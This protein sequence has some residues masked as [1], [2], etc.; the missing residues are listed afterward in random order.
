MSLDQIAKYLEYNI[1]IIIIM[2]KSERPR[3]YTR[4][5]VE[6]STRLAE[7]LLHNPSSIWE[8][9]EERYDDMLMFKGGAILTSHDR[10]CDEL[11][12]LLVGKDGKN[13]GKRTTND[14][15]NEDEDD[16]TK[17]IKSC[18]TSSELYQ[19]VEWKFA[20]GKPRHALWKFLK[21][22][23][24]QTVK[25]CSRRA[26]AKVR[27][28]SS[29]NTNNDDNDEDEDDIDD[30]GDDIKS[31]INELTN[32]K[33]VGPATA[34]AILSLY[35]PDL[36]AFMDDEIIECLYLSKRGYTLKIYLEVNSKCR[37]I[38][39]TLG[40]GWNGRRVG[41][42]LWT[43]AQLCCKG[44]EDLTL[45]VGSEGI[46]IEERRKSDV[47]AVLETK[48]AAKIKR[49]KVLEKKPVAKRKKRKY[50]IGT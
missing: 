12:R 6:A 38:A 17:G 18:I 7:T 24:E 47:D 44:E 34:S 32:L 45:G 14:D 9:I 36:F 26:F 43:A 41:R 37:E 25:S 39:R 13:G 48:P 22:N 4:P 30:E 21:A 28:P 33:G 35:R 40:R 50:N 3:S 42:A 27:H 8:K 29:V 19:V 1:I 5:G 11:G 16:S 31:A 15:N 49:R 20:K 2:S 46:G 23:T 10:N